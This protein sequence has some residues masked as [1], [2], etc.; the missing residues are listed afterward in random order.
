M[1]KIGLLF[2]LFTHLTCY[3]AVAQKSN[4]AENLIIFSIDGLRWHEVFRGAEKNLLLNK[5]FNSQDSLERMK[6]YWSD[7]L[8]QRRTNLILK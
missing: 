7:D 4:K 3:F 5:K 8:R 2:F 1:K 6:K